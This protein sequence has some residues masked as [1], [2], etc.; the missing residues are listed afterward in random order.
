MAVAFEKGAFV[1]MLRWLFIY[2]VLDNQSFQSRVA[3][4]I[5]SDLDTRFVRILSQI[6]RNHLALCFRDVEVLNAVSDLPVAE[7]PE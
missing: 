4:P 7:P 2:P 6:V 3:G 1:Q 5:N